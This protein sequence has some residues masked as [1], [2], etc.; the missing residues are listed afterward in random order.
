MAKSD[1]SKIVKDKTCF[2]ITPIGNELS[3]TRRKTDGLIQ[4]VIKPVLADLGF[5]SNAAHEIDMPGSITNQV[6]ERLLTNDLVIANLS[7]LNPNVM[8]ELAV[9]HAKRLP[10]VT[11]AEKG[12]VLPFDIVTERTI[13]Y[14]DDMAGV[15]SLKPKLI[16]A[17]EQAMSE[18][19][20]DN[21]IYRASK[22]II[23]REKFVV[24]D[25]DTVILDKLEEIFNRI[26]N[27]ERK[28][29]NNSFSPQSPIQ[30]YSK[31]YILDK[32]LYQKNIFKLRDSVSKF[33]AQIVS[34]DTVDLNTVR[35]QVRF[36]D[37]KYLN[38]IDDLFN[39]EV[40]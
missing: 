5:K 40:H 30:F 1:E 25:K 35:L 38:P 3:L 24:G 22:D 18:T 8:Y 36:S 7:E 17:I 34:E 23:I 19:E 28:E 21:P 10:V 31:T 9:R 12:T 26:N 39:L 2:I 6:I 14:E 4:A 32:K 16:S 33:G 13:F 29:N 27:I 37:L 11:L 15:E 20:I